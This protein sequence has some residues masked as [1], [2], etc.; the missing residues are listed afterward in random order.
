[1]DI[2]IIT[3]FFFGYRNRIS[4]AIYRK[5]RKDKNLLINHLLIISAKFTISFF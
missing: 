4:T 3:T 5:Q 2:Q 1:M